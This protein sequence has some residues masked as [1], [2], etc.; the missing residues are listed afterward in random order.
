MLGL[1]F[2]VTLTPL[3]SLCFD[4]IRQDAYFREAYIGARRRPTSFEGS[5]Q[6]SH[7]PVASRRPK[8]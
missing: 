4:F 5:H 8:A 2:G 1:W 6:N 3:V 7:Q